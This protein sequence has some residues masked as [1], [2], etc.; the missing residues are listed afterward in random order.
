MISLNTG[1]RLQRIR[2]LRALDY[3]KQISF[4]VTDPGFYRRAP[5]PKLGLFCNFFCRIL[6]EN[7]RIW[8]GGRPWGPP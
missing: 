1:F 8:I 2:L 4:S 6:H 3:N 7:E 5:I